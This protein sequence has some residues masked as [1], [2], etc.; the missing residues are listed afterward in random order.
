MSYANMDGVPTQT[1]GT[2]EILASDWNAYVRDNFDSI[3]FGH[4][5]CTS[6]TRPSGVAEGVMI[7]ETDTDKVLVY[8]GS[9]WVEVSDLDR[10]GAVPETSPGHLIVANNT[11]KSAL[12][13]IEG[14]MVYQSD[15]NKVFVYSGSVWVEVSDIDNPGAISDSAFTLAKNVK[16][17][18]FNGI[19]AYTIAPNGSTNVTHLEVSITPSATSS[20]I[21]L[22]GAVSGAEFTSVGSIGI[23]L[24]RNGNE[25]D[26]A[27]GSASGSQ[28]RLIKRIRSD[29]VT[30]QG[31]GSFV[32]LD[33]P[34][35]TS[36]V[37]YGVALI[38]IGGVSATYTINY[39]G[40]EDGTNSYA[41]DVS[42]ITAMEI[43]A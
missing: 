30:S 15:N 40:G 2:S 34:N 28:R 24:R 22:W 14:M 8:D 17:A 5:V 16:S 38:A 12:S 13:P 3:K 11:A 27:R 33:S 39:S 25:I 20:K 21:L 7:Y 32:F 43:L 41:R 18:T 36:A 37:T 4:I 35:T 31:G 29:S 9:S 23:A 19:A 42:T 10:A 1:A 6:T 26:A